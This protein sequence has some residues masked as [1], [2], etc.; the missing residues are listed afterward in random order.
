MDAAIHKVI[1]D[2]LAAV[3]ATGGAWITVQAGRLL[4]KLLAKTDNVL[5]KAAAAAAVG[6]VEQRMKGAA[7]SEKFKAAA[8]RLEKKYPWLPAEEIEQEIEA[9]VS[10]MNI[11]IDK[12]KKP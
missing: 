5:I 8:A 3:I 12:S 6:W 1:I 10:A 7:A 4:G 2:V 11:Q 9:A